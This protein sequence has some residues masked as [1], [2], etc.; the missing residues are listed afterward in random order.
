M[1]VEFYSRPV[2]H[3]L[4]LPGLSMYSK[5]VLCDDEHHTFLKSCMIW[6]NHILLLKLL[7]VLIQVE[8]LLIEPSSSEL[9]CLLCN[10]DTGVIDSDSTYLDWKLHDYK[11]DHKE[12]HHLRQKNRKTLHSSKHCAWPR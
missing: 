1:R 5:V 6:V 12:H 7:L 3:A 9:K 4:G 8:P 2:S 11:C 10:W